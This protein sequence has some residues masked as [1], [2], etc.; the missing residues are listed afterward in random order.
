MSHHVFRSPRCHGLDGGAVLVESQ[1]NEAP[2]QEGLPQS[3]PVSVLSVC[4]CSRLWLMRL[5]LPYFL[6]RTQKVISMCQELYLSNSDSSLVGCAPSDTP[7][8][9]PG[10]TVGYEC[11]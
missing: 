4:M 2:T 3:L 10:G 1:G 5:L 9:I 6:P 8:P 11:G 7:A